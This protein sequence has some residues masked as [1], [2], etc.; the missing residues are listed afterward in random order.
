VRLSF[1]S[2]SLLYPGLSVFRYFSRL[3]GTL[4][5]NKATTWE[6]EIN[7]QCCLAC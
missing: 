5:L 2:C 3:I 6:K 1:I 7:G 4:D